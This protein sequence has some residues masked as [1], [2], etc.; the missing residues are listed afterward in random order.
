MTALGAPRR[1]RAV[2]APRELPA[3]PHR[4]LEQPRRG[5]GARPRLDRRPA[6]RDDR[7]AGVGRRR[8]LRR[9]A[10]HLRELRLRP[11]DDTHREL[12]D[13][14]DVRLGF[15]GLL[16]ALCP[17]RRRRLRDPG[18]ARHATAGTRSSSSTRPRPA[19]ATAS[20]ASSTRSTRWSRTSIATPAATRS[21][22]RRRSRSATYLDRSRPA[23]VATTSIVR[24]RAGHRRP[25]RRARRR[26]R[27]PIWPSSGRS[28]SS[29]PTRRRA[30][31]RRLRGGRHGDGG[32]RAG[33]RH[34]RR[35]R[36][37]RPRGLARGPPRRRHRLGR[38]GRSAPQYHASDPVPLLHQLLQ[39]SARVGRARPRGRRLADGPRA[40]AR[41]RR[42]RR[43]GRDR[44]GSSG[45][46]AGRSASPLPGRRLADRPRHRAARRRARPSAG[47][48]CRSAA[49]AGSSTSSPR[50]GRA[51]QGLIHAPS[52]DHA[53]TAA[54]LRSG[55]S[56]F[57]TEDA[58][59]PL[60]VDLSAGRIRAARW[61]IEGVR[62]G[63]ELGRLLG[64]R[65]ERR[66][67]DRHLDRHIDDV[68]AA[69]LR[70]S[71]A[72]GVPATR[73]VD[74][75]LVARAYTEGIER[76]GLETRRARRARA[77][78]VADRPSCRPRSTTPWPTSTRSATC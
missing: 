16:C 35:R 27:S 47:P 69:V 39:D 14:Y 55:W 52:L 50:E 37:R 32:R 77:D 59:S 68:R 38:A 8:D 45:C 64:G 22:R 31:T 15:A 44:R 71:G 74:G 73:I 51:S 3:R 70:G 29:A 4:E 41:P 42:D 76:H 18:G 53:T 78:R 1:R 30:C 66:L 54:V 60:A 34:G 11:V 7:G 19:A 9:D 33:R 12:T 25:P 36:R 63:Q 28:T 67:H 23:D 61:L 56:A 72:A 24:R 57:G 6:R 65:F 62:S 5:A 43:R 75:L 20:A 46:C 26:T 48:G 58:G 10:A 40:A 13:L 49:T 21:R 2:R 17:G